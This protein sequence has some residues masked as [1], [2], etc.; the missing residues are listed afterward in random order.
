MLTASEYGQRAIKKIR[1]KKYYK[2]IALAAFFT[3]F[4]LEKFFEKKITNLFDA[5][6]E[7]YYDLSWEDMRAI[8]DNNIVRES[9]QNAINSSINL[10][11]GGADII[12]YQFSAMN[13]KDKKSTLDYF[14]YVNLVCGII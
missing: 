13:D 14:D 9:I 3:S 12:S 7:K 6:S 2:E 5:P 4:F 10:H 8:L 11:I 1:N